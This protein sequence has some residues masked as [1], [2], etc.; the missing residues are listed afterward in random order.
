MQPDIEGVA[1]TMPRMARAIVVTRSLLRP[2]AAGEQ[3]APHEAFA[4]NRRSPTRALRCP[5]LLPE[6]EATRCVP[7]P[8]AWL[9]K[10]SPDEAAELLLERDAT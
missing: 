3:A 2:A 1:A 5:P 6:A 9:S 4:P 10:A 7:R 8:R